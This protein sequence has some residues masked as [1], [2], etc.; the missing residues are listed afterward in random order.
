MHGTERG[1]ATSESSGVPLLVGSRLRPPRPLLALVRREALLR[2]LAA[3][4]APLVVVAAP[5]GYG[6]TVT[7]SQWAAADGVPFAWLQAD[8]ADNDPLVFLQYLTAALESVID[9]DPL[10]AVAL[11]LA[12]PPVETRIIPALAASVAAAGGFVLVL[13]DA[14]LLTNPACWQIV[15]L[16]LESLPR[17]AHICLSGRSEPQLPL[18]RLKAEGRVVELG[19][20]ELALDLDEARELLELTGVAADAETV[21]RL[22]AVTEGWAVGLSLAAVAGEQASGRDALARVRGD[23]RDIARYLATEVLEQQPAEVAEFLLETSVLER[24]SANLCRAVTG[25]AHAADSLRRVTH[26]NLF[27]SSLDDN[28]EWYRYHHLFAEFLQA[29]LVRRRSEEEVAAL[30]GRAAAWFEEHGALEEAVRHWLA[31]GEP[32]RA[33]AIVCGCHM[34]YTH[35]AR[36]QTVR[37]W[38]DM[39]TDEQILAD[40]ALT[41][42]AGSIGSM[43]AESARDQGW[44]RAALRADVGDGMWPGSPVSLRAY[45]LFMRAALA[46][47]SIRRMRTDSELAAG[48]IEGAPMSMRAAV[49]AQLG[50]ACWL[51]GDEDEALRHLHEGE[52]E[53]AAANVLARMTALGYQALI[54]VEQGCWEDARAKT[55]EAL[56][57]FE[58]A[59]LTVGIPAFAA[60][61]ARARIEAHDGD[62]G[63]VARLAPL[64]AFADQGTT[65]PFMAVLCDVVGGEVLLEAGDV[66]GAERRA[67]AGVARLAALTDPGVLRDRL[68]RLMARAEERRLSDPLT[69]AERRVLDLLP[70]ELSLREI[71]E[72]LYVSRE[73][74]RTH[75][76]DIYR[77]LEAHSR[78]EAVARAR[79]LGLLPS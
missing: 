69:P 25:R 68:Q 56:E 52:L 47:D 12:P 75:T 66:A 9:V 57:L 43:A 77:K 58:E 15:G 61:L 64:N 30:H 18:A 38:L 14:H 28:G 44:V 45:Q 53:G 23:R 54:L 62:R 2:R 21:G 26:A 24:L 46:P 42:G 70:T 39:F 73:T 13:D 79:E 5:G 1:R 51:S 76:R 50:I 22:T 59:G 8:A 7:L 19:P 27:L 63:A 55:A 40:P 37:R 72:R 35:L 31:G 29:E 41:L 3:T 65:P 71:G 33:G 4:D 67:R 17:K 20:A 11:Q 48:L 16:L 10:V 34:S 60:L 6:K 74:V 78:T 36:Y 49:L 32:G